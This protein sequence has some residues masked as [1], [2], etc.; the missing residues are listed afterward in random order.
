MGYGKGKTM[1]GILTAIL[2]TGLVGSAMAEDKIRELD[3]AMTPQ[4]FSE[5]YKP[6]KVSAHDALEGKR[7]DMAFQLY[8]KAGKATAFS[9]V[10]A[11]QFA[12]AAFALARSGDRCKEA[13][14][15]YGEAMKVQEL[16][17]K[18][19]SGGPKW[20]KAR[21]QTR[22]DIEWG[23]NDSACAPKKSK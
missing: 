8:V 9:W 5:V 12:N 4:E 17:E 22:A 18:R 6:L 21:K 7:F 2:L 14:A 11:R 3:E 15:W 16:A 1:K 20:A 10:R 23:L 19:A 13:I